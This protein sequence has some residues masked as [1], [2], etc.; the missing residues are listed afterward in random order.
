MRRL[1][2]L[3]AVPVAAV[4]LAAASA[5]PV[6]HAQTVK[7]DYDKRADFSKYKTFAFR[8]GT[9]A[10]TPFAQERIVNAISTQLKTRGLTESETPDLLVYTHVQI[11]SEKRVDT[12]GYGY[13]GYPG[14]GGWGGGFATTSAT[15]TDIPI[16]TLVTDVVDAKSNELVWRGIATD[17][18]LTNPT[19]E[20]SEKRINKA[21]AKLFTKYPLEPVAEKKEKK[22]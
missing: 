2:L 17:T 3:S 19:P 20:K 13:G 15:V 8:K 16:G 6:A 21:V 5:A 10:P 14:W 22:K 9:D 18:L 1:S 12:T 7:A 11:S 4:L